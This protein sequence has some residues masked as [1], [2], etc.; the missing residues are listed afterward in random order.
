MMGVAALLRTSWSTG[1]P[2]TRNSTGAAPV[3][4]SWSDSYL[5]VWEKCQLWAFFRY[6]KRYPE[7]KGPAAVRGA[8][9]HASLE[10]FVSEASPSAP[11][12][13]AATSFSEELRMLSRY[14]SSQ[15]VDLEY[16]VGVD[17]EWM[18]ASWKEAWG[19]FV[20]DVRVRLSPAETLIIDYKSGR[21]QGNEIKHTGQGI[22]YML[23]ELMLEP[24]VQTV[25]V[26]F[27]YTDVNDLMGTK[28]TRAQGMKFFKQVNE[29]A[30][31][32]TAP[33][34]KWEPSPSKWNCK[35][36]PYRQDRG[37]QCKLGVI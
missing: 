36:C 1:S 20:Y 16:R 33:D 6:V 32:A 9:V 13:I 4:L 37:G 15:L 23:S 7:V 21:K 31:K 26:E 34:Q 17:R 25:H 35:W 22:H 19:R 27:W 30:L 8:D 12:P 14:A 5:G 24:A 28:Y 18:R 2:A 10:K 29:T 11:V 3:E